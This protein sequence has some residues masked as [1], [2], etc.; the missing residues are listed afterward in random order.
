MSRPAKPSKKIIFHLLPNIQTEYGSNTNT[1]TE[2]GSIKLNWHPIPFA[3]VRNIAAALLKPPI[4][5]NSFLLYYNTD[6]EFEQT[7]PQLHVFPSTNLQSLDNRHQPG[8]IH[9]FI[10]PSNS[11]VRLAPTT[12]TY[13]LRFLSQG[14]SGR[15]KGG[16][17]QLVKNRD[18]GCCITGEMLEYEDDMEEE[19][20][21]RGIEAIHIFPLAFARHWEDRDYHHYITDMPP[22]ASP[23]VKLNSSQNGMMVSADIHTLWD[24]YEIGIDVDVS[25]SLVC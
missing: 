18:L 17:A 13:S 10:V 11:L 14:T 23:A 21:W 3:S 5:H 25:F 12:E 20:A 2:I 16:F 4:D 7:N 6:S 8:N 22:N 1:K 9:I 24:A 19:A 15:R